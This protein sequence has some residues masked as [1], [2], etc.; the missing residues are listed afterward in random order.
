MHESKSKVYF[1]V[2]MDVVLALISI[3]LIF[4]AMPALKQYGDSFTPARTI[5][6]SAEGKALVAP[7]IAELSFSVVTEGKNPEELSDSNNQKMTAVTGFVK[8]QGIAEKD[9]K[10]AAYTLVPNYQYNPTSQRNFIRGYTLTQTL[11]VKV[12]ELDKVAKIIAGLTPLGVNQVGGVNFT[13]EDESKFFADARKDAFEKAKKKA[14][15][16]AEKAGV[17]LGE[18]IM[19]SEFQPGPIPYAMPMAA[20]ERGGMGGASVSMPT[21]QPGTHEV[22]LAVSVTYKIR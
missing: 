1:W 8:S 17:R 7:D 20:L 18:V 15:D 21:L 16:I 6:V 19:S 9:L 11:S 2:L 5:S 10:T 12:R 13:V 3:G 14:Q 22:S 4:F